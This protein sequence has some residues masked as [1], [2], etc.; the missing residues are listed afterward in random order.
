MPDGV[1]E[2]IHGVVGGVVAKDGGVV[3]MWDIWATR[4]ST[5]SA[6]YG[7]GRL[8]VGESMVKDG[9]DGGVVRNTLFLS[10]P[11]YTKM[12]ETQLFV[13]SLMR[14]CKG[15]GCAVLSFVPKGTVDCLGS[16]EGVRHARLWTGRI[17]YTSPTHV[18]RVNVIVT[19]QWC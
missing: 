16:E 3:S 13:R 11:M 9:E 12:G 2:D 18:G 1:R 4:E 6:R 14:G 5:I 8:D 7:S 17:H 10:N 19:R 15:D